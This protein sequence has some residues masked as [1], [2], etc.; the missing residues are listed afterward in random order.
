MAEYLK[1]PEVAQRLDVS[2][3]TAR[4]MVK[5]GKLPSVFIGGAYRVSEDDLERYLEAA[6]VQPGDGSGKAQ[7]PPPPNALTVGVGGADDPIR[8]AK[9]IS[10]LRDLATGLASTWNQDVELYAE[11]G[12]DVQPYR[13][14][15]M[16]TA[17]SVL[18]Q[19]FW[20]ALRTLQNLALEQGASADPGTWDSPSKQRL[21]ETL[22]SI[23][24][25]TE[26]YKVIDQSTAKPGVDNESFRARREEFDVDAPT[27][28]GDDPQW[29][30]AVEKARTVA[31]LT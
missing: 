17:V 16:S 23:H 27:I 24:A 6:K 20:S 2:E 30:E 19:Q 14:Y 13:A 10:E 28:L 26:L 1:I 11:H 25:L 12:R 21:R 5:G 9:A 4:R 3:K 31:G 22:A 29:P 15:E 18:Y 7:A 8:A